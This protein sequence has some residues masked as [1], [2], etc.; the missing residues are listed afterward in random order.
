MPDAKHR[1]KPTT[2]EIVVLIVLFI[3]L[4]AIL[5]LYPVRVD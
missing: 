1:A 3:A 5:I 2:A 4:T